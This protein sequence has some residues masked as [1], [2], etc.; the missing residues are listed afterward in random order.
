MDTNIAAAGIAGPQKFG[1]EGEWNSTACQTTYRLRTGNGTYAT[2]AQL[3]GGIDGYNI[4]KKLLQLKDKMV[5]IP[6]SAILRF[7]YNPR[8]FSPFGHEASV[9][10]R[11]W[12]VNDELRTKI[13]VEGKLK[14]HNFI[15]NKFNML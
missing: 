5:G 8:G 11:A 4:G 12:S 6:L 7:Y 14:K 13:D 2:I 3:K 15:K 9:C 1:A 10:Q